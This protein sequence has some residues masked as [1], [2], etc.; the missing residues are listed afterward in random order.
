MANVYSPEFRQRALRMMDDYRRG[1][2]VSEWAAASAVGEKLGVS[3]H[4]GSSESRV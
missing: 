4:T 3:P 1:G 2:D